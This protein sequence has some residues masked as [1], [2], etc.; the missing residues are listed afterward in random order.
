MIKL[1]KRTLEYVIKKRLFKH[2]DKKFILNEFK[3]HMGYPLDLKN[4]ITF[5]EKINW[6]KAN[7]Y[8]PLYEKCSDKIL[9]RD[10]I[11][12]KGY[13]NI[14]T[15]LYKIYN[16]VDDINLKDLP[17]K[18]VIK[19]T[20]ASG[21]V[22]VVKNKNSVNIN[23]LKEVLQTSLNNSLYNNGKEWQYKNLQPRI[24]VEEL[25]ETD[26]D[27]LNDYK[28]FCFN[29]KVKYIYVAHGTMS[30][31]SNYCIDFYDE[32]WNY[33]PVSRIGHKNYGPIPKPKKFD[34]MVT[35]AEALSKD[36]VHVRVDLYCE[37]NKIYFG[38]LT[39]TTCSGYGKFLPEEFDRELGKYID[40]TALYTSNQKKS[41]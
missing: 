24:M 4:P 29:G 20:H 22:Y 11:K 36:F 5:N 32:K 3:Y 33:V 7:Y 28:F 31:D 35:I 14:L 16:S 2:N 19:T 41:N 40:M 17:Q 27:E 39:F 10:Y 25:I 26:K 23:A 15:K 8:N 37:H 6:I 21:G 13:G 1:N 12:E 30:G 9:V 18:F 34:D 38:E